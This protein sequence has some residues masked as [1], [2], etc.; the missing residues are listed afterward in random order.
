MH[1]YYYV[2]KYIILKICTN[3]FLSMYTTIINNWYKDIKCEKGLNF[4]FYTYINNKCVYTIYSNNKKSESRENLIQTLKASYTLYLI[5]NSQKENLY[6]WTW[7]FLL[8][9]QYTFTRLC[10]LVFDHRE[11]LDKLV[12]RYHT[13]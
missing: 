4:C 12:R 11:L 13:P 9:L 5:Y 8:N 7:L 10:F 3:I 1:Y 2:L 6:L